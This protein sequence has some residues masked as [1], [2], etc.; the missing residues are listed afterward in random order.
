MKSVKAELFS[1]CNDCYER[2]WSFEDIGESCP[3]G[4]KWCVREPIITQESQE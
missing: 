4:H 1:Y 3:H 2:L